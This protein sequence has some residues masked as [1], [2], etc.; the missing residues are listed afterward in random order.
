VDSESKVVPICENMIHV[1]GIQQK[2]IDLL[3]DLMDQ[4]QKGELTGIVVGAVRPNHEIGTLT[5]KGSAAFSE[6]IAAAVMCQWD[7]CTKWCEDD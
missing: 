7:L 5:A 4:A 3:T 1:P 6:L 2:V